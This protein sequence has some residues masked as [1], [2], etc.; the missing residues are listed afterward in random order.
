M[1]EI[2]DFVFLRRARN[3]APNHPEDLVSAMSIRTW[4]TIQRERGYSSYG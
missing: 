2:A 1:M 3:E 4:V